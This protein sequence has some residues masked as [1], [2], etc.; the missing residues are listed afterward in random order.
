MADAS[1]SVKKREWY[2]ANRDRIL[3]RKRKWRADNPG[4]TAAHERKSRLLYPARHLLKGAKA[5]AKRDGLPFALILT[6]IVIPTNCPVLGIELQQGAGR[7]RFLPG[8]PSLDKIIPGK[9]Y[10]RGNV[11]VI[12]HR[13]NTIKTDATLDE[14]QRVVNYVASEIAA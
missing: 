6:D 2:Y 8:S 7:G 3:E 5:R 13:A 10:V 14:L 12:S 9:G 11:R 1:S 4:A